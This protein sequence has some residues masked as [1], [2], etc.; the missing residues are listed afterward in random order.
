M[1]GM[2]ER[3]GLRAIRG[4]PECAK[5]R[6]ARIA[7]TLERS[8]GTGHACEIEQYSPGIA[9]RIARRGRRTRRLSIQP[10]PLAEGTMLELVVSGGTAVLP[11]GA[12][13]ADIGVAG[14]KIAAHGA[15]GRP[16]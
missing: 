4:L 6:Q 13:P 9:P 3:T 15:P 5:P 10:H 14:G 11:S 8:G 1:R 12:E 7:G 2:H 16:G